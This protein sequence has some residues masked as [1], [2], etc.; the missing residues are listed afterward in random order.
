MHRL[1]LWLQS[2]VPPLPE[3]VVPRRHALH[4]LRGI[5]PPVNHVPGSILPR[6]GIAREALGRFD[7]PPLFNRVLQVDGRYHSNLA[8]AP[9]PQILTKELRLAL[10]A[11]A[12]RPV[13]GPE[14]H[15]LLQDGL[16]CKRNRT[17]PA[18]EDLERAPVKEA[19]AGLF[20]VPEEIPRRVP[21]SVRRDVEKRVAMD[22]ARD[23][24]VVECRVAADICPV[25]GARHVGA[26]GSLL[27]KQL[28]DIFR[29]RRHVVEEDDGRVLGR[30][31]GKSKE[32][33]QSQIPQ[34][35][36]AGY[37]FALAW[38]DFGRCKVIRGAHALESWPKCRE[39]IGSA[40]GGVSFDNRQG[41]VLGPKES[42]CLD[43]AAHQTRQQREGLPQ[44]QGKEIS[45]GGG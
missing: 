36:E 1:D 39:H 10:L 41:A 5:R 12:R 7:H 2:L 43:Y 24:Y 44:V 33:R 17:V 4:L 28:E 21:A 16:G 31:A 19:S 29:T 35:G 18:G 26:R 40:V 34:R 15:R 11:F 22:V 6:H 38:V 37:P 14:A 9:E 8:V 13:C 45:N 30:F 27:V 20:S 3:L 23:P 42:N 25:H 32:R